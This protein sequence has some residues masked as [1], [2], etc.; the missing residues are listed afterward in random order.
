MKTGL[1]L[2]EMATELERQKTAKRDFLADSRTLK[3]VA[4]SDGAVLVEGLPIG[5]AGIR[6]TAHSQFAEATGIPKKYYRRMAED[7][8]DLLAR[9][10]NHWL[11]S[12]PKNKLVRTM[13]GEVR[14]F[15][16]DKYRPLDNYDFASAILPKLSNLGATVQSVQITED[17]F[18][19]KAVSDRI[20]GEVKQG[21]VIQAGIVASNSEVG[22]GSLKLEE[23]DYR[24]VCT[25]GMIRA[26]AKRMTH[27]GRSSAGGDLIENSREFFRDETRQL[28]DRTLW[29]KV[30][31]TADAMFDQER[32][33]LRLADYR[34]A[35]ERTVSNPVK[36][37]EEISDK[38]SLSQDEQSNVLRHLVEGGDLSQWG[39]ANAV[40][41]ASQDLEDYGRATDFEAVG[42]DI[43]ELAPADWK[44]VSEA[45]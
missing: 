26:I 4:G 35:A 11:E 25:N 14:A 45:S 40:T 5:Q 44:I 9:N 15:L 10:L 42:G 34:D 16:S 31:D 6:K 36:A 23:L 18:Y 3:F 7:A 43:I 22:A 12:Q 29:N 30:H 2:N 8:P 27:L 21:D 20:A 24:L 39:I 1:S 19:L 32:L 28:E 17:R 13:D 41:R 33:D 37:I 38:F